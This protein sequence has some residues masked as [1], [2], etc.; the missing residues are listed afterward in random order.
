MIPHTS[1]LEGKSESKSLTPAVKAVSLPLP[2]K[3]DVA[4]RSTEQEGNH[5]EAVNDA[6][7]DGLLL[8]SGISAEN[9]PLDEESET[10]SENN[11]PSISRTVA[12]A[13]TE[14]R[15]LGGA[16][17]NNSVSVSG[18]A[19]RDRCPYVS[20]ATKPEGFGSSVGKRGLN[21]SAIDQESAT[22]GR[23]REDA[24]TDKVFSATWFGAVAPIVGLGV[25]GGASLLRRRFL[26]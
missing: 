6:D 13:K 14:Q 19:S 7:L 23:A 2:A 4:S 25:V 21:G 24:I 18:T 3:L 1:D 10:I 17:E 9:G 11:G 20:Q 12:P 5:I 15:K 16:V 26:K 22:Y 8:P